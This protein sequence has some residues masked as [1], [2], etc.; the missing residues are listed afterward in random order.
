MAYR[1]LVRNWHQGIL[2]LEE[3][4]WAL[5]VKIFRSIEGPPSKIEFNI[6]CVHLLKGNLA[7]ALERAACLQEKN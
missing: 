5:A 3:G 4:D 6:G 7:D 2:A 1:D